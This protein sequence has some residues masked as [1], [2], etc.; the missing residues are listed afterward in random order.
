MEGVCRRVGMCSLEACVWR[1]EIT[2]TIFILGI[3]FQAPGLPEA[4]L[5][6]SYLAD[7]QNVLVL[8]VI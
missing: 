2:L 8:K 6:L 7:L 1:P 3:E 4:P 5:L